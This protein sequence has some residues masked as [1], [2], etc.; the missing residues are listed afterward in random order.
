MTDNS[1]NAA[2]DGRQALSLQN[3]VVTAVHT[4]TFEGFLPHSAF[5][6]VRPSYYYMN[7]DVLTYTALTGMFL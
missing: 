3:S 1:E 5:M 6:Y 7:K 4:H 2:V